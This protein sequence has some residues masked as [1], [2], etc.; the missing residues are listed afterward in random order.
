MSFAEKRKKTLENL[1]Q[2]GEILKESKDITQY[3]IIFG[4]K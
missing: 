1:Q 3:K 2:A 4:E